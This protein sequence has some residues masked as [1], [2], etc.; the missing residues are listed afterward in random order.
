MTIKDKYKD[1]LVDLNDSVE[2]WAEGSV[3]DF[4]EEL[5]RIMSAKGISRSELAQR[6]GSSKAYITKIF[7]GQA[8]F[9]VETMTK[10]SL[11]V[12]HV[13]RVH[14]APKDSRTRWIDVRT[15]DGITFVNS[16][17]NVVNLAIGVSAKPATIPTFQWSSKAR[18]YG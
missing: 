15:I 4:T 6:I 12:D 17:D 5:S 14:V 8:N 16:V 2:Y 9:T 1:V 3:M 7:S 10:L 18:L 11:A 13:V